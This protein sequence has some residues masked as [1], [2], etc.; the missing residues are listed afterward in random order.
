VEEESVRDLKPNE[1]ESNM[2]KRSIIRKCLGVCSSLLVVVMLCPMSLRSQT[3]EV[4]L[5][6]STEQYAQASRSVVSGLRAYHRFPEFLLVGAE[7]KAV[8]QMRKAG[9]TATVLDDR[10]WIAPYAVVGTHPG[11]LRSRTYSGINCRVLYTSQDFDIIK[12]SPEVFEQ[13]RSIGFT[14]FEIKRQEIQVETHA[15]H[16]P[17]WVYDRPDDFITDAIA[18]V[19]DS[20]IRATIQGLGNLGTRY[21]NNATRDSVARWVKARYL[22][23][24]ITDVALDSF[25][26][27]STWQANV[28]AT[29]PGTVTPTAELIVGGHH[30]DMP[31]SG[32]APG[33]DDNASGTAAA[34][35]M[36]RV[37]RLVNYQPAFTMRFMGYAAEEAGLVGSNSY[38]QRA[39]TANR[40]IRVM[41]NYDM[42]ANRSQ[43]PTDNSV[44]IVWYTSSEA[45]RD[46]QA[47]MMQMYTPLIPVPTTSYRSQSDSYSF[48]LQNYRT[49]FCIERNLSPYYHTSN[50]LLQYLDMTYCANI[51]KSGL[52]M[53]LTL[54]MMPASVPGLQV[55]DVGDGNSLY[56]SWDSVQVPDW[57]RYKVYIGTSPGAYTSN[58]LYTARSA[59]L[60]GLTAGTR[61][62]V[63]VSI[64]DLAGREGMIT[65]LSEV[66]RTIPQRP[67]GLSATY[68]QRAVLRWRRNL[69]MDLRGYNVY[70]SIDSLSNFI[71]LN[72]QPSPDTLWVD[73]LG[74]AWPRFYYVTAVDS[75]GNESAQSDTVVLGPV[76]SVGEPGNGRPFAF[77]LEQN[78]P[79]PFNPMTN[80]WFEVGNSGFVS[81]RVYDVLGRQVATLIQEQ[82]LPGRYNIVWDASSA[83][84]GTYFCRL[85]AGG[86]VETKRMLLMK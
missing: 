49:V 25:Q 5:R 44:S 51:V 76:V 27:N 61:Y 34:I 55:R 17:S 54:D 86:R 4:L 74:T 79:N 42:I 62:Y 50:D 13:L 39:R 36:A 75:T 18:N 30:D 82:K 66:P 73:T 35:E 11:N 9:L 24:G 28:V 41:Q 10:P 57:Y 45:Y 20:V 21:W 19:S 72:I 83:S 2:L 85:D 40:D 71:R 22:S 31:S 1:G 52:A 67:T 81:V 33:A 65:E 14:C 6:I 29:I 32:L 53:L 37:L 7:Q 77:R 15:T 43:A 64:V 26:Y 38:A 60:S 59:R 70:R 84:S 69:E 78:Y 63:G 48:W 56:A 80:I 58:N 16:L 3:D 46:L 23:T 8:T 47:S 12:A 68:E